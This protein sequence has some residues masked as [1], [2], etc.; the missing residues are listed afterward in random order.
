MKKYKY[1]FLFLLVSFS[2][3]ANSKDKFKIYDG[4]QYRNKPNFSSYDIN[5]TTILYASRFWKKNQSRNKI[6]SETTFKELSNR[7]DGK[8]EFIVLDIEHWPVQGYPNLYIRNSINKY[9]KF[10]STAKEHFSKSKLGYFGGPIPISNFTRSIQPKDSKLYKVWSEDNDRLKDL[11]NSTDIL[12]PS[13]YTYTESIDD[14]NIHFH[15]MLEQAKK[16]NPK[17]IY[18]FLW[19]QYFDHKPT[20]K[21]LHLKF[22]PSHYWKHQLSMAL[23]HADGVIIWGGWDFKNKDKMN[24]DDNAEWWIITK[25]FINENTNLIK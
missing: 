2:F 4:T 7:F 8:S 11:G 3:T 1:I 18:F 6:P 19:P 17:K 23:K 5:N 10:Y 16:F 20:P 9:K 12:F 13:A 21:K 15:S 24:W 22:I 14:W 25:E